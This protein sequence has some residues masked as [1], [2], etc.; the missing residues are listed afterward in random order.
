MGHVHPP[1]LRS[2]SLSAIPAKGGRVSQCPQCRTW[3][4]ALWPGRAVEIRSI[5][6]TGRSARE[7]IKS[8]ARSSSPADANI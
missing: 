5:S 6:V 4:V 7:S 3:L 2:A 1:S 8:A